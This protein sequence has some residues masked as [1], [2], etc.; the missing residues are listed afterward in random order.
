M[1]HLDKARDII[2]RLRDITPIV[3]P[4]IDHWRNPEHREFFLEEL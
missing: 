4:N 3:I 1:G 2:A